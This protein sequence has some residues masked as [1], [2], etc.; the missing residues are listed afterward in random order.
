[1]SLA[2]VKREYYFVLT[3]ALKEQLDVVLNVLTRKGFILRL[4]RWRLGLL[5]AAIPRE[6]HPLPATL[7]HHL[8]GVIR[9]L[10]T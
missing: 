1:M 9:I 3:G 6:D 5:A 2:T 10:G 4:R 7:A 8:L